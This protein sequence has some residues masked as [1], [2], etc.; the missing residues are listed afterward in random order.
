M[1]LDAAKEW[2]NE[3]TVEPKQGPSR[4]DR[5]AESFSFR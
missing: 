2:P 1:K 3:L 4:S 5:P